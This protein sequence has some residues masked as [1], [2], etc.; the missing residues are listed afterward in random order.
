MVC[1]LLHSLVSILWSDEDGNSQFYRS[2]L[3]P[4]GAVVYQQKLTDRAEQTRYLGLSQMIDRLEQ[5]NRLNIIPSNFPKIAIYFDA[6]I[7]PGLCTQTELIAN[8]I[9]FLEIRGYGKAEL[10]LVTFHLD[11]VTRQ[12]LK[13]ECPRYPIITSKDD[14]YFHPDWFHDSPMPPAMGDRA[15]LLIKY[16]RNAKARLDSERKSYLP[17]CLFLDETYWINLAIAKD[18][19]YMGI[20]GAISNVTLNASGNSQRFRE[21]FTMGAATAIEILAIPEFWE[22]HLFSVIDLSEIQIAGGPDF[23]AEFIRQE[24]LLLLSKNPVF[25]DFHAMDILGEK[26][27]RSKLKE[28]SSTETNLFKFAKELGLGTAPSSKTVKLTTPR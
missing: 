16:P 10:S 22:K 1:I 8:V 18:D 6:R 27:S 4:E 9:K 21:D 19:Y 13:N 2:G 28:K 3:S 11:D 7:A 14:K 24:P 5:D 23:N 17:A 20:D 15:E 12:K 25:L 26:R